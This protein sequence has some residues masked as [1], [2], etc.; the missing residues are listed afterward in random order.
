MARMTVQPR[1]LAVWAH[2]AGLPSDDEGYLLHAAMRAA[3]GSAAPQ[4]WAVRSGDTTRPPT[5]LGYGGADE[6]A[7][8]AALDMPADPLLA[9]VFD[10]DA[11]HT[12]AMPTTFAADCRLA[13]EV[14]LCP[15]VRQTKGPARR[16][17][18]L[19]LFLWHC[20]R[21]PGALLDRE[22]IYR[23]WLAQ[24]LAD[25][26]ADLLAARLTRLDQT[27]LVRRHHSDGPARR[28]RGARRPDVTFEGSL[29]VA[30]PDRFTALLVRGI[31]RH[32]AFGFGML[33]LRPA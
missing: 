32:R 18:E 24:R 4:P 22:A 17:R 8:A 28:R 12:K 19:D 6:A 7:L 9:K 30:D 2:D 5:L 14:R 23:D 33:L 1:W 29:R 10:R 26:G 13:F 27:P 11:I 20:L 3:F 15:V 31:G 21:Q 25:G 16:P